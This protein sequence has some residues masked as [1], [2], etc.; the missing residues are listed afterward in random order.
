MSQISRYLFRQLLWWAVLVAVC[1]TF[2][3]WLTQSLRFVEMIVNRGLSGALF[4]YFTMLLLPTFLAM[5]MPIAVFA[6]VLF[7]Y[8]K[9]IMDRELVVMRATGLS[10]LDLARPALTLAVLATLVGYALSLYFV[11][12]S[13]REFKDLQRSIRNSYASVLLQEG[14]FN[15]LMDGITV[16]VRARTPEGAL[17]GIVIHDGRN[18]DAPVTMMAERGAI[19]A[20]ANGPRVVM[21]NGNRQQVDGPGGKVSLLYFDRYS[22]EFDRLAEDPLTKFR[23]PR[24]RYLN[25]LLYP[26]DQ[27]DKIRDF[28]KFRMEGHDRLSAP[29]L[30]I[31]L[32]A[33]ALAFLLGGQFNRR[34]QVVRVVAA[35]V[36][37]VV[38]QAALLG[39]KIM[40]EQI[41]SLVAGMYVFT[42]A[43]IGV[44]LWLLAGTRRRRGLRPAA[45]G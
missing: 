12:A 38:V 5:I 42:I 7:T 17:R 36:V 43:P 6:A 27:V 22:F 23:E 11:P 9:L 24:E 44:A 40:G 29:L 33:I 14:V 4:L 45:A 39:I 10:Q 32:A 19:V 35:V 3:V 13:F 18:P 20:G 1:L 31:T 28:Q 21:F 2:I 15:A 8:N 41:P 16:Y 30:N 34:G 25:E 37:A 26:W